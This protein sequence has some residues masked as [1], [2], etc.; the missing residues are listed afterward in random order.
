MCFTLLLRVPNGGVITYSEKHHPPVAEKYAAEIYDRKHAP[1]GLVG[2]NAADQ[3]LAVLVDRAKR[4]LDQ[5]ERSANHRIHALWLLTYRGR[6]LLLDTPAFKY[7]VEK[8][9]EM[10]KE[11][12]NRICR[13]PSTPG[14]PSCPLAPVAVGRHHSLRTL[15]ILRR[16]QA[17]M[18]A[19]QEARQQGVWH[20]QG[21]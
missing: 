7:H 5:L 17:G 11:G 8:T 18:G 1:L 14:R 2:D 16:R 21:Q 13:A 3:L 9:V 6:R 15:L 20:P 12:K 10:F 4:Q 19:R